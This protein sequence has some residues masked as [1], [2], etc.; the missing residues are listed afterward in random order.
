METK[1]ELIEELHRCADEYLEADEDIYRLQQIISEL[2]KNGQ[3]PSIS[4]SKEFDEAK[5][6]LEKSLK[7]MREVQDKLAKYID[8]TGG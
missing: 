7:R 3:S 2:T 4:F 6:K 5:E 1:R 8:E